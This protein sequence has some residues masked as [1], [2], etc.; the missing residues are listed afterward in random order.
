MAKYSKKLDYLKST[1][2][3]ESVL[4]FLEENE[5]WINSKFF[6]WLGRV[7]TYK[8]NSISENKEDINTAFLGIRVLSDDDVNNAF[9]GKTIMD[10][11]ETD[12]RMAK[13]EHVGLKDAIRYIEDWFLSINPKPDINDFTLESAYEESR[14][15]HKSI[16]TNTKYVKYENSDEENVEFKYGGYKIVNI[17]KRTDLTIE[18]QKMG[19]CVGGGGYANKIGKN[20]GYKILS[21]RDEK[22]E[23]HATI[24]MNKNRLL[25]IKGKENKVPI[26]KYIPIIVFW[27]IENNLDVSDCRDFLDFPDTLT[28]DGVEY[29]LEK[30]EIV[31]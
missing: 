10:L 11:A 3:D 6:V 30:Y 16:A 21:V 25:Q 7:L 22:N 12:L 15:W 1:G 14:K 19:H 29:E 20:D 28:I 5:E 2:C 23:P 26:T 8:V 13:I 31:E 27:I 17:V 9:F 4:S 24:E 18:G